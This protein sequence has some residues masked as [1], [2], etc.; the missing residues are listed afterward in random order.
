MQ[1]HPIE[2]E[3]RAEVG[4]AEKDALLKKLQALGT[5]HSETRRLS[6][7]LFGQVKEVNLD[8]RIRVTNGK[9]EVVS[10][11]GNFGSHNRTE[12]SQNIHPDQFLGM[13]KLFSQFGFTT[14]VGERETTNFSLPGDITASLVSAGNIAYLELEKIS[15][16]RTEQE[17]LTKLQSLANELALTPIKSE[18]E[19]E[20]LCQR[21]NDTVDWF[22]S[23]TQEDY[24]KL[25]KN[26]TNYL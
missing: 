22:F 12:V 24:Q 23:Y 13:V 7:M 5:L 25:E 10:K 15:T 8:I 9:C 2:L 16:S 26:L 3:L 4:P 19:F 11:A 20:E 14:K 6:V 18:D 17:N 21:L 1:E